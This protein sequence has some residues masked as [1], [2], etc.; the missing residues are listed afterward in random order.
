MF[1]SLLSSAAVIIIFLVVIYYGGQWLKKRYSAGGSSRNIKIIDRAMLGQDKSIVI[2]DIL[3]RKYI[4]AVSG[5]EITLLKELGEIEIP[6]AE[7][8]GQDDFGAVLSGIL[9]TKLDSVK[10]HF[11]NRGGKA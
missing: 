7:A 2:A 8:A 10:D 6:G 4:I 1:I 5:H 11:E 9:K 3:N